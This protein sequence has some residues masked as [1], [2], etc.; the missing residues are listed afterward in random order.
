MSLVFKTLKC[1]H[2]TRTINKALLKQHG[3]LTVFLKR[4][5]FGCPHCDESIVL[6]E[7]GDTI[8]SLGLLTAVILAPLCHYWQLEWISAKTLLLLGIAIVIGG[9]MSQKFEKGAKLPATETSPEPPTEP[10]DP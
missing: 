2:C 10:E 9:A 3:L 5:S 7:K 4:Q 1:P 6:P 8:I